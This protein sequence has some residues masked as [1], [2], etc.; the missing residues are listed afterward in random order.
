VSDRLVPMYILEVQ[1]VM[2]RVFKKM[3]AQ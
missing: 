3:K 1:K 2:V